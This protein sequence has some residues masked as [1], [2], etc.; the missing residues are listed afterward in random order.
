MAS[1]RP[2][3]RRKRPLRHDADLS[4][5]LDRLTR[6]AAPASARGGWTPPRR[7][8]T[9]RHSRAAA[10]GNEEQ[11]SEDNEHDEAL[12]VADEDGDPADL[13]Q[14]PSLMLR[15]ALRFGVTRRQVLLVVMLA[16]VACAFAAAQAFQHRARVTDVPVTTIAGP[17]SAASLAP[18]ASAAPTAAA[19]V[20][21]HVV[22][23]VARPGVVRLPA[24]AR[25]KDAVAAAGG[26]ARGADLSTL[27]LARP[28]SD[29]E[30][31]VVGDRSS[32]SEVPGSTP[33]PTASAGQLPGA[34]R[35]NLNS[36]TLAQL[37]GLPHIGPVLAQRILDFRTE[38]GRF[39]SVEE[40][41]EVSG[42]GEK[43]FAD[44]QPLVTV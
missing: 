23:R 36:A 9:G 25:V 38:H 30:Q 8:A 5:A 35:V 16:A 20:M 34:G 37:D 10:A 42:I 28:L 15:L 21:V 6:L 3:R 33:P 11:E 12:S 18:A 22:G 26:P 29:G 41:N 44:L 27:N 31:V 32:G 43:T 13:A 4:D 19:L 14:G 17:T 39:A 2:I 1:N 24:G 40:L 7:V